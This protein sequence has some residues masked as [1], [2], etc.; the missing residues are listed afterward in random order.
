MTLKG[1]VN[2]IIK[3]KQDKKVY[4]SLN[5]YTFVNAGSVEPLTRLVNITV[6]NS[7]TQRVGDSIDL[8]KVVVDITLTIPPGGSEDDYPN[9]A[10]RVV[11]FQWHQDPF[12]NAPLSQDI[13][14]L[15]SG[16][17]P[18]TAIS[19]NSAYSKVQAGNYSILYDKMF[20]MSFYGESIRHDHVVITPPV[21]TINYS[22]THG[23]TPSFY[24][25]HGMVY[26]LMISNVDQT[27]FEPAAINVYSRAIYTDS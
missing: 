13:I 23:T 16:A 1:Y 12:L 17:G 3:Q 15:Y 20:T 14:E 19:F 24:P 26:I 27:M 5:T 8:E 6:G 9:Y 21:K 10:C 4:D 22:L 2:K 18:T 25:T 11:M 7:M